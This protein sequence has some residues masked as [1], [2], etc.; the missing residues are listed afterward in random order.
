MKSAAVKGG[1]TPGG[2]RR[3]PLII[4][5]VV[6]AAVVV[7]VLVA[8]SA[9][10]GDDSGNSARSDGTVLGVDEVQAEFAGVP[11]SGQRLGAADAPVRIEE[12]ADMQCPFCA[13]AAS[14]YVPEI[15]DRFVKPGQ[16]SLTFRTMAF[17]G[18]DSE[19]GALAVHAAARQNRM[20]DLAG[21][22]Y[23]NQGGENDGWLSD[24]LIADA[25]DALGIDR[26][27]LDADRGSTLVA[28]TMA[29]DERLAGQGGVT[30]TPTF[31]VT[32]PGGR[33]VLTAV[34]GADTIAAAIERVRE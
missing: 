27:K 8:L 26:A 6:A 33:E 34:E 28:E 31:I 18:A 7:G 19:R 14:A 5:V 15:V 32:G 13:R 12:F 2:R 16:A 22:L 10:G 29:E 9:S 17:I 3:G 24:D 30:S 11:Q 4:A 21:V 25:A 1:T 20:W 23:L